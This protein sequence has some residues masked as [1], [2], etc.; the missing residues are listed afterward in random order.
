MTSIIGG[1]NYNLLF[2]N[3]TASADPYATILST[4]NGGVSATPALTSRSTAVS[5]GSPLTDLRLAQRNQTAEVA[6]TAKD[7]V[8][9]RDIAA[10]KKSVASASNIDAALSNPAVLKV[11]LNANNLGAQVPYAGLAKKVLLSDPTD[12]NGLARKIG[13]TAWLNAAKT[14]DF[15]KN[16]LAKLQDPAVVATLTDAYAQVAWRQSLDKATPGLGN[17]LAFLQQAKSAKTALDILGDPINRAV[18][19]TALGI[20]REIAFQSLTAQ[21]NAI[22]ARLDV[23]KLQDPKFVA[24]LTN[25]YLLA[26]QQENQTANGETASVAAL[27]QQL[28][29]LLV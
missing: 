6:R 10:F 15:K 26:R 21:E 5:T 25:R 27:S 18:V 28:R 3:G 9:A 1:V 13:N 2:G 14:Y 20:P 12:P 8:V 11:L 16:G 22:T 29:S 24:N 17:A 4:L 7:P 19:T 23:K